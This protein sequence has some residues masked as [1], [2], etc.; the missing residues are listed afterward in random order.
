MSRGVYQVSL[1][2]CEALSAGLWWDANG[3]ELSLGNRVL[4]V[5]DRCGDGPIGQTKRLSQESGLPI[6]AHWDMSL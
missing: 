3:P 6:M 2:T 1:N 4:S 5:G